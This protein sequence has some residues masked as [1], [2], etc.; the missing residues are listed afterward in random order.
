MEVRQRGGHREGDQRVLDLRAPPHALLRHGHDLL[1]A[2]RRHRRD[3]QVCENR[4]H[5][6]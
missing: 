2:G 4:F 5:P 6:L 1:P 3:Q